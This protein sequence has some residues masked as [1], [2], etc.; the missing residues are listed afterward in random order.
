MWNRFLFILFAVTGLLASCKS[1]PDFEVE[2]AAIMSV[3]NLQQ[4]AHLEKNPSMLLGNH[5]KDFIEVNRGKI[6]QP[7]Y[8]ESLGKFSAYFDAVEFIKWEDITPP[9][10][11]FSDDASMATTVVN[12]IV[13]TRSI[14]DSMQLDTS[15][16]AWMAV[17]TKQIGKWELHRMAS[18]NK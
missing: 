7:S 2:R 1:T 14:S 3:H 17:Y 15:Y 11:S 4:M 12:K 5:S 13:I 18:T 10:I 8:N 16:Y 6:T 9:I